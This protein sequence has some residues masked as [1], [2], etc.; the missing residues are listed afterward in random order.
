M[1]SEK[2]TIRLF[3]ANKTLI[4]LENGMKS[5]KSKK[6]KKG[7]EN[8]LERSLLNTYIKS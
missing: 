1:F 3:S 4:G 7:H 8:L 5:M 6:K 2:K